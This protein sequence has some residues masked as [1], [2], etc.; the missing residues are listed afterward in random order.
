MCK[1][2]YA[3][4][5][6]IDAQIGKVLKALKR[7]ELDKNTLIVLWGDHG[8]H[9]G[10]H[11][12]WN[13]HSNFENA[14][15]VP[16]IIVDPAAKHVV[17]DHPVEFLDLYPT[18]CSL[19]D[20]PIL[21]HTEGR[22]LSSIVEHGRGADTLKPYAVSQYP[23]GS[24]MG[25]SIRDS[26][27]RYTVWVEWKNKTSNMDRIIS[28]ELYDYVDDTLESRNLINDGTHANAL[29][30]MKSYWESYKKNRRVK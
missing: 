9:L 8:W 2:Y 1:R 19:C 7:K 17:M 22:D 5:S 14:T 16:M 13:K 10:D 18:I 25:Y 3:C 12:L 6:Y 29:K 26:R 15:H 27:Y 24:R 21:E 11:G 28:E 20:L 23:K 4:V 30:M